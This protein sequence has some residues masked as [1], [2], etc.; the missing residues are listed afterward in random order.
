[1]ASRPSSPPILEDHGAG[2]HV[3]RPR[4]KRVGPYLCAAGTYSVLFLI[5]FAAAA[6]LLVMR[7]LSGAQPVPPIR[8]P[9]V[10]ASTRIPEFREVMGIFQVHETITDALKK[11]GLSSALT[12]RIIDSARAEYNLA[13]VKAG[14]PFWVRFMPDGTFGDFRYRIDDKQYLTVF[15]DRLFL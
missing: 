5:L 10:A 12:N 13:R 6:Y 14:Q 8:I 15:H 3:E 9:V 4:L 7:G 2:A 11:Q 1:M